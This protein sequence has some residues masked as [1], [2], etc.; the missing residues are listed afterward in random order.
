M[1]LWLLRFS[2]IHNHNQ[3]QAYTIALNGKNV[4]FIH[5]LSLNLPSVEG[6]ITPLTKSWL[7]H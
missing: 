2:Y 3:P 5:V 4:A 7:R 6:G 1:P